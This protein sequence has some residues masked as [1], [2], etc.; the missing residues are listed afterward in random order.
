M[1]KVALAFG[2][3]VSLVLVSYLTAQSLYRTQ[4][5]GF[6]VELAEV[7]A[8][9][10]FN[11]MV[12]YRE[13]ESYIEKGCYSEAREKAKISKNQEMELLA[14]FLKEHPNTSV[15]KYVGDRDPELI[16]QLKSFK[17]PYGNTWHEPGCNK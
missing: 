9:L 5:A 15:N 11:H 12:R 10:A 4:I 1:K 14:S 7:Q 6:E 17:N 2:W 3:L 8:E 16:E 13:L